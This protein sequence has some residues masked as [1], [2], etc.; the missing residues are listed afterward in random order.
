M[1]TL[2]LGPSAS[3]VCPDQGQVVKMVE[4]LSY[5]QSM[6]TQDWAR[7]LITGF[8]TPTVKAA[9]NE[10]EDKEVAAARA[11]KPSSSRPSA[12]PSHSATPSAGVGGSKAS[13]AP[14]VAASLGGAGSSG[15]GLSTDTHGKPGGDGAEKD[16]NEEKEEK[17][18]VAA[19]VNSLTHRAAHAR[20]TRK[21][22]SI[23]EADFPHVAKLWSGSRKDWFVPFCSPFFAG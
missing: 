12:S 16:E 6:M 14:S 10:T 23:N 7:S 19:A 5:L 4:A 9:E 22:N 1:D 8:A 21:M 2:R 17:E 11:G 18:V 13:E 20:L 3:Q 15:E